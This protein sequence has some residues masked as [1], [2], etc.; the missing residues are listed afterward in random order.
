MISFRGSVSPIPRK[1]PKI[2]TLNPLVLIAGPTG[3]GKSALALHLA[4]EFQGEVINCDS[5]QIYRDFDIGS[6][7]LR[8][9]ERAGIPHH[10][11]DIAD[12]CDHFTAGGFA[13]AARDALAAITGRG[14]LPILAGGTG[15]YVRAL[16]DGLF[17]GPARNP[18][19]RERL[20]ARE[21]RDRGSLYRILERLDPAAAKRIHQNDTNKLIRALEVMVTARRPLSEVHA[22]IQRDALQ[23]YEILRLG[24]DPP[25]ADLYARIDARV[26]EMFAS[27][28]VEEVQ[29]LLASGCPRSAKAFESLG[30]AQ[31]LRLLAGEITREQAIAETQM[32]TR[33]YA[34][35]QWT[36][37]RRDPQM[38]WLAGFGTDEKIVAAARQKTELFREQFR[39]SS[40]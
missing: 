24:L 12:P 5:V 38:I 29:R 19:I 35:R 13:R 9:E 16:I 27:G 21:Q 40:V 36:W 20:A 14:R 15:F 10:L 37:F 2:S 32:M 23:G 31:T 22:T 30:Y 28:L 3:S 17:E 25:R 7:K 26:E 18:A 33:R 1:F 11:I 4:R 6:A 39:G 34:K 8:P